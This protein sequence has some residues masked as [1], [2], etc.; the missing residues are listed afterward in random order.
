MSL[1]FSAITPHPPL[2][3]PNIGKDEIEKIQ[4]TKKA[5]ESLEQNLYLAKPEVI[6]II[7]PHGSLFKEAFC[8][9]AHTNFV[10][11]FGQFGDMETK[12]EWGGADF[13]AAKLHHMC[14][15]QK[16]PIQSI[17]EEKIDHG[18][19]VPLFYLTQHL[20]D[21]K[22]LPLGY[23]MLDNKTHL[24]FGEVIKDFIMDSEKRV[25]VIASGDLSHGLTTNAPAGFSKVGQEFDNKVI[26]LLETRNTAGFTNMD[27]DFVEKSAECGYRSILILL[28]IMKN[29][30]YS[31][32]NYSYEG[33]FGVGYL[34]GNFIF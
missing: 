19:S 8:V 12:M 31:F 7:S 29:M 32:K 9:N 16:I 22:I 23:S 5:M 24:N 21:V 26:E 13:L 6:V 27:L 15:E 3:I 25:A 30:D 18:S 10:S 11:D 33:P 1:I 34:V 14:L 17:S 28:G 20:P 2:L 4:K